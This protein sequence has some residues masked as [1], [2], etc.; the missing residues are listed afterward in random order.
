MFG[1]AEVNDFKAEVVSGEGN[2]EFRLSV[3][4]KRG[5]GAEV[6]EALAGRVKQTFE[7]SP[8]VVVLETGTLGKEF[9]QNVKAP[10]FVDR[11]E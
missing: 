7:L 1:Q 3:E 4:F 11:R 10:R 8:A 6:A 9:E 5:S 2:D